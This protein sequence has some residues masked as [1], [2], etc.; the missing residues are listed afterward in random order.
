MTEQTEQLDTWAIVDLFGHQR[1]AGRVT[2]ST[3]AGG[4]FLRVDVPATSQVEAY[5][6][7]YR[8]EAIYSFSPVSEEVARG[9]AERIRSRPVEVYELRQL[10]AAKA[11]AGD[12]DEYDEEP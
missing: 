3:F 12:C 7:F 9:M 2:E 6:R 5:T 1:I 4:A 10:M 8:P 11:N